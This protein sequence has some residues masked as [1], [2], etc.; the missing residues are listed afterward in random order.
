MV[1][2]DGGGG[3]EGRGGRGRGG[4]LGEGCCMR[5]TCRGFLTQ[6]GGNAEGRRADAAQ[7]Q[8]AAHKAGHGCWQPVWPHSLQ[9]T[10][11][12]SSH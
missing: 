3:G 9:C 5:G 7:P 8:C 10:S 2:G 1:G 11:H 4:G 6:D 12:L